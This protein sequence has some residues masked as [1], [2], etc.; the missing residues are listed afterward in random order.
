MNDVETKRLRK[1]VKAQ[2]RD[3]LIAAANSDPDS[4]DFEYALARAQAHNDRLK[5]I[6]KTRVTKEPS[7]VAEHGLV[8]NMIAAVSPRP[9]PGLSSAQASRNL[10]AY[11]SVD[12]PEAQ[13]RANRAA[14][15]IAEQRGVTVMQDGN[16]VNYRAQSTIAGVGGEF[17][18]PTAY[19]LD[20][21]F[22]VGRTDG[23][24]S[25]LLDHVPLPDGC[26]GIIVPGVSTAGDP[27]S[28]P[29]NT[30]LAS[31]V[32]ATASVPA[33]GAGLFYGV[34][35]Y[36]GQVLMSQQAFER[37]PGD[38]LDKAVAQD[39]ANGFLESIESDLLNGT[40]VTSAGPVAG[41]V[42]GYLNLGNLS[43]LTYTD[44]APTAEKLLNAVSEVASS[45]AITR[46][47]P[48][49]AL[50]M[51]GERYFSIAGSQDGTNV[52]Q[53][54][55]HGYK[56][57]LAAKASD[58]FGPIFSLPVFLDENLNYEATGP[59]ARDGVLAFRPQDDFMCV[60]QPRFLVNVSQYAN[61]LS[62]SLTWHVYVIAVLGRYNSIAYVSGT[63][64]STGTYS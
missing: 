4:P 31:G 8:R 12:A 16:P 45:V 10:V 35:A 28:S 64:F 59:Q 26:T 41:Q 37:S 52:V 9:I 34:R 54:M 47:R 5:L 39:F 13:M 3:A 56:H 43:N 27:A 7:P 1:A 23:V 18:V 60:T 50:L 58:P 38:I 19:M 55:G 6:P 44:A 40:G 29:E 42:L 15:R 48:P 36:S 51:T 46:R 30:G 53:A 62:V 57:D 24:V 2:K 61:Q 20:Q 14:G 25:A 63:G 32:T 17:A 33:G 21:W 49:G 22:D 11:R